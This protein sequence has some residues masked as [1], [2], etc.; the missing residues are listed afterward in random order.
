GREWRGPPP[1]C[2]PSRPWR[3][4]AAGGDSCSRRARHTPR[5]GAD[6]GSRRL[7]AD[8]RRFPHPPPHRKGV[9]SA[10]AIG[11]WCGMVRADTFLHALRARGFGPIVG[12][13]CSFLT[14]LINT[15]MGRAGYLAANNEG[16]AVA[17]ATGAALA[18][19]KPVVMF[20]NSGLGNAVS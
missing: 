8:G 14:G 9:F 15:A 1:S 16:E 6:R 17:I 10:A 3:G 13:P 19:R 18:G 20:Q 7:A 4:T 11:L 2:P 12:V 5:T